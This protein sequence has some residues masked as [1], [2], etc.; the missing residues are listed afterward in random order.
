MTWK[1][2]SKTWQRQLANEEHQLHRLRE[3]LGRAKSPMKQHRFCQR[4]QRCQARILALK[5]A[6]DR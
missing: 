2:E 4:I 5:L 1:Q 3:R 6:H